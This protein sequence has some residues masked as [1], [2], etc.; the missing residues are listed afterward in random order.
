MAHRDGRRQPEY[1]PI[2]AR[3]LRRAQRL[4]QDELGRNGVR[5]VVMALIAAN[6]RF[7]DK[8]LPENVRENWLAGKSACP[9]EAQAL[10]QQRGTDAFVCQ[11]GDLGDSFTATE[12]AACRCGETKE[13]APSWCAQRTRCGPAH[14][15]LSASSGFTR[16]ARRAGRYP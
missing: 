6:L 13:Y 16:D 2:R 3:H 1:F 5:R 15:Y 8:S 4:R 9:T 11:P 12:V 7:V 10:A 14:S